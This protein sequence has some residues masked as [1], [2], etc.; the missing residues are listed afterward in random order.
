[1]ALVVKNL[2][3]NAG[4]V[5]RRV[6]DPWV[7]NPGGGNG[8]PLQHSCLDNPMDRG[9][10]WA[11]VHRVT[12]SQTQLKQLS[13]RACRQT[14]LKF[15]GPSDRLIY[16]VKLKKFRMWLRLTGTILCSQS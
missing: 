5:K 16:S 8:N 3:A 15:R 12:K 11:T 10:W 1:M 6:L 9:A 14:E 7:G 2:P 4:D 13:M